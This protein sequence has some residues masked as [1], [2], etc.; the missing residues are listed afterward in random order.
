[1]CQKCTKFTINRHELT[2][3]WIYEK[4]PVEA[5]EPWNDHILLTN[6]VRISMID[7]LAGRLHY[8]LAIIPDTTDWHNSIF[9]YIDATQPLH[10]TTFT[11]IT[12]IDQTAAALTQTYCIIQLYI[13][14]EM[15]TYNYVYTRNYVINVFILYWKII[16]LSSFSLIWNALSIIPLCLKSVPSFCLWHSLEW[17]VLC[18]FGRW[19]PGWENASRQG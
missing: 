10:W 9:S 5:H 14:L 7:H 15:Q 4:A 1:M 17:K 8:R 18:V 11:I 6:P 13:T 19:G 3:K 12:L 16:H 2:K